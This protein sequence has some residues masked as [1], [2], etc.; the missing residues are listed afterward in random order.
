[1]TRR[2]V[3]SYK[4]AGST[5]TKVGG[6]SSGHPSR[7]GVGA[8]WNSSLSEG[9]RLPGRTVSALAI[10]RQSL[11]ISLSAGNCGRLFPCRGGPVNKSKLG[12]S[13]LEV[14]ALGL[15]CIRMSFGLGPDTEKKE[16]IS[17]IRTAVERGV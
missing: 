2:F 4:I 14:S 17:L 9:F 15:G 11:R 6:P 12:K 3:R 7:F 1:M 5:K 8:Q 16:G 13:N 10:F